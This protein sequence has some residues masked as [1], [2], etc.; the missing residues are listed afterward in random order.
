MQELE[1][2]TATP[3]Y[4]KSTMRVLVIDDDENVSAAIRAILSLQHCSTVLASRAHAGIYAFQQSFFDVVMVDLFMPGLN[5]FETITRIREQ[6][7]VPIIAIS[8]FTLRNSPKSK[9]D[10][11]GVAL[12]RG[13]TVCLRKPF[14][15][16][17]L[18]QAIER[19]LALTAIPPGLSQ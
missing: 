2:A 15:P 5:G 11:L 3:A 10:L 12:Q 8:G 16:A 17:Q 9:D 4:V 18:T 7:L 6:S 14:N 1:V 13:A 19:S